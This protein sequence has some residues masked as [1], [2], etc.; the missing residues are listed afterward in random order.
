LTA[1]LVKLSTIPQ[2]FAT[3]PRLSRRARAVV[4][5]VHVAMSVGWLGLDA[6]LVALEATG[7]SAANP[8]VPVGIATATA[9]IACWVLIPVVFFSLLSGLA[10]ALA[11]PWG[12]LRYWWVLAKCGIAMVL[13]ATGLLYLVPRLP[14]IFAGGG[15]P[16]EMQTLIARSVA[17]MLLLAATGISVVKPW[18]KT[19]RGRQRPVKFFTVPRL[20]RRVRAVVLTVH[21]ATSIGWLG[22]DGALVALEV[23]GMFTVNPA[24]PVGIATATAMIACWM[25]IP[26]VFFSLGSGLALALSTPSDLARYYW[27]V[28]ARCGIAMALAAAG[29]L[30]LVPRLSEIFVGGGEPVEMQTLIARSVALMLLLAATGISVVK[31]WGGARW[32]PESLLHPVQQK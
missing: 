26:V 27:W 10:L 2:K 30:Y 25:L 17:L 20:S 13:S 32:I 28:L 4:L 21:V 18:G 23:T 14:E 9:M 19:P 12:L 24:V 8:A 29:L 3:I 7:L 31:P 15:E 6:A 16:V 11:T 5:T 22:L 1:A